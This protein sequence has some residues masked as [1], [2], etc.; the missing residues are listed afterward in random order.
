MS[1]LYLFF[2]QTTRMWAEFF[3]FLIIGVFLVLC[4]KT[5]YP[6]SL[7]FFSNYYLELVGCETLD[8]YMCQIV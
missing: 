5:P 4:A 8:F 2:S 3:I 1:G 6:D 7:F